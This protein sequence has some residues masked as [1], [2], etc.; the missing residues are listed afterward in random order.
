[1]AT[2]YLCP[3]DYHCSLYNIYY[4]VLQGLEATEK[5]KNSSHKKNCQ[6]AVGRL[7]TNSWWKVVYRLLQNFFANSRPTVGSMLVC[8]G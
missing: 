6:L 4:E 3:Q 2:L 1:M 7:L 5:V 8:V